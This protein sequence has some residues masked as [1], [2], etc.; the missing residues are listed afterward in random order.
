MEEYQLTQ[1]NASKC[2]ACIMPG[3]NDRQV[4]F[5]VEACLMSAW[6]DCRCEIMEFQDSEMREAHEMLCNFG[7]SFLVVVSKIGV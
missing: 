5:A 4:F 3:L 1:K 7:C 2:W 6:G